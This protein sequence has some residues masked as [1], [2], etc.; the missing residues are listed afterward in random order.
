VESLL[1]V[2]PRHALSTEVPSSDLLTVAVVASDARG[3]RRLSLLLSQDGAAHAIEFASVEALA[4]EFTLHPIA[5]VV[6]QVDAAR[7]KCLETFAEAR[8]HFPD[9]PIVGICPS[10][11]RD[12]DRRVVR[13]GVDGLVHV[14]QVDS[15]LV[16]TVHAVCL[17]LVCLPRRP[18][19]SRQVAALSRREKEALAMLIM[20]F[21]N[22]EIGQRLYLAESTVKSHLSSAYMKL[23]VRSRK[24]AAALI[25]DPHEG[26]GAGILSISDA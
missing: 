8:Q 20:G 16:P 6:L 15:A 25:L 14:S 3:R 19:S 24:D 5:A 4:S 2:V 12:D 26:L 18:A 17:G 22:A 7:S 1:S 10:S 23:G 11:Q 13:A 9:T 21:T